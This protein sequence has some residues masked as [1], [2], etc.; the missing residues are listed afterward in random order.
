MIAL[1]LIIDVA[2]DVFRIL[3]LVAIGLV[4]TEALLGISAGRKP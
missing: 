4:V 1:S 2:P 3:G